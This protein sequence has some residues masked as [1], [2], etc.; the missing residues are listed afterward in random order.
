VGTDTSGGLVTR[1]LFTSSLV[2]A[3]VAALV[4]LRATAVSAQPAQT[5]AIA[6]IVR[7]SAGRRLNQVAIAVV[8]V[9]GSAPAGQRAAS[10]DSGSY[11]IG[12]IAVGAIKLFARRVGYAPETVSVVVVAGELA[13]ADFVMAAA[14]HELPEAVV[15]ADPTRGKMGPFNRRKARG[16]GAFITRADIEKRRSG[17]IS[18]LL[19]YLPGVGVTQKM[20]GEPQPVH[21]QRSV[22]SSMQAT[23][24]VQLYV[25]GHPY[26]NGN[27]DDFAPNLIE[28]VEVYRSASEIPADFRTRDAT[29]GLIALWTRDPEAARR[30]P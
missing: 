29:C 7:D 24:V 23:C 5:G 18:E 16:V 6:G 19:R 25:D 30:K 3:L 28:G 27:V 22:N 9:S 11:R 13:H 10:D 2:A 4:T 21:M 1:A 12:A 15:V 17:S 26:P 20:A 8:E 14:A